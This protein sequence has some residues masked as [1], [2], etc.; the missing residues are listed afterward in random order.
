MAELRA[1]VG[2]YLE[3]SEDAPR[4]HDLLDAL[5]RIDVDD[6]SPPQ[7]SAP[8]PSLDSEAIRRLNPTMATIAIVGGGAHLSRDMQRALEIACRD[9]GRVCAGTGAH[10]GR[11]ERVSASSIRGLI[12]RG[13]L[14]HCYSG[15]G[16]YAGR[17]SERALADLAWAA[18]GS[19]VST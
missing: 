13:Y 5:D 2:T 8:P 12:R 14:V 6:S 19:G 18:S 3:G 9:G 15:E 16:G 7:P 1:L 11:L 4:A 17:L 10:N